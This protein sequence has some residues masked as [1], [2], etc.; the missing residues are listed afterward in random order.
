MGNYR[1]AVTIMRRNL[2]RKI[3][4]KTK[5][6]LTQ[7]TLCR[8]S[9]GV[10]DLPRIRWP[11]SVGLG[12]RNRRNTQSER[13]PPYRSRSG[14]SV[15]S[16]RHLP[17]DGSF[18]LKGPWLSGAHGPLPIDRLE[19][20]T[21]NNITLIDNNYIIGAFFLVKKASTAACDSGRRLVIP[22]YGIPYAGSSSGYFCFRITWRM[23]TR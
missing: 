4:R 10:A 18:H 20:A 11:V 8:H 9:S 14:R 15:F 16:A 23:I 3:D 6:C 7:P 1:Y 21:P 5:N 13:Q 12:G 17:K 19:A 2:C 22:S